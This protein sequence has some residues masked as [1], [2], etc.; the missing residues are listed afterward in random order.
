VDPFDLETSSAV[1]QQAMQLQGVKVVL[2][3]RECAIQSGR[4]QKNA[5]S[6]R[7]VAENCNL[8]KLCIMVTG[9][10]ALEVGQDSV[11]VDA[12]L[13]RLCGLC[14]E[15]CNRDALRLEIPER[16]EAQL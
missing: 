12:D 9:C 8:C 15:V 14:V 10:S 16:K 5:G 11:V 13:C 6:L 4:R 7:V 2:A 3:R 1:I